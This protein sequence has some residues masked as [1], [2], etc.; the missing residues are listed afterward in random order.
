TGLT[1]VKY[2]KV[3]GQPFAVNELTDFFITHIQ[4]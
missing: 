1:I 4:K 2:N 3:S